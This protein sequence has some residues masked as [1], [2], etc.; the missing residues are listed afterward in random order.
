[1][2]KGTFG[3][4]DSGGGRGSDRDAPGFGVGVVDEGG[5]SDDDDDGGDFADG[6]AGRLAL[7]FWRAQ[8]TSRSRA[9]STETGAIHAVSSATS[10]APM[11]VA[12]RGSPQQPMAML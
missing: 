7:V 8:R 10:G 6:G 9:L 1:M 12:A 11:M 2:A 5:G 3:G 4:G